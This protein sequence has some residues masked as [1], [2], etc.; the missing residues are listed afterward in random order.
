MSKLKGDSLRSRGTGLDRGQTSSRHGRG[1]AV[2]LTV[3]YQVIAGRPPAAHQE[4]ERPASRRL[5]EVACEP[6]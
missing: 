3:V 6:V 5:G 1:I 2:L 4:D